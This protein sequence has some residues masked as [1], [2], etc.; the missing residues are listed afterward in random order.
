VTGRTR[1]W[2]GTFVLIPFVFASNVYEGALLPKLL[3]LQLGLL[4][5]NIRLLWP[6]V[7]Q[8]IPSRLL[9]PTAAWSLALALSLLQSVNRTESQAQLSQYLSFALVPLLL[10]ATLG[11]RDL[12]PLFRAMVW[13]SIPVGVIGVI[14]YLGFGFLDL[15]SNAQP[16]A[17]FFHRNAAAGYL[18]AILPLSVYCFF[19]ARGRSR[20]L[21]AAAMCLALAYLVFTRTR[22][23]WIGVLV[24]STGIFLLNRY[25]GKP[26]SGESRNLKTVVSL[27]VV[28]IL[29]AG[30]IPDGLSSAKR[31][32]FDDKKDSALGAVSSIVSEGGDRGRPQLWRHTLE[33]IADRAVFGVG[34]GNW[35]FQYPAYAAGDH[36]NINAAPRRPHN[37]LL[38][39]ASETGLVGLAAYISLVGLTFGIGVRL[40]QDGPAH[41]RRVALACLFILLAH[42]VDGLFNFPRERVGGASLFWLAVGALWVVAP[43]DTRRIRLSAM[44]GLVPLVLI[45]WSAQMTVRRIGYDYHHLQVHIAERSGDWSTVLDQGPRALTYGDFRANTLIAMGRAFYRTGDAVSAITAHE[46]ALTLHPN[47][48]NAHNNLGIA[49]RRV[50]RT[51][52]AVLSLKAAIRLYPDFSQAR[53]NLGNALRDRGEVDASIEVFK[54]LIRRGTWLPQVHINLGR[55]FLEKGDVPNARTSYI[56]ALKLDPQ[57]QAARK[58]LEALSPKRDKPLDRS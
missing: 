47:S 57:N 32:A 6:R 34:L 52:E 51:D 50:G 49:Y 37:D 48:L 30:T 33:M 14:Q 54:D 2:A 55:S 20:R 24:A 56:N 29:I 23:A 46:R 38:W 25:V 12:L 26:R 9:W 43:R 8:N 44:L 17:M 7:R 40:V 28:V 3:V 4:C 10:T 19:E 53:N 1:L 35:E 21:Y 58:A 42:T 22:G 39:I 5:V 45:I 11:A 15:P 31:S 18:T 13:A 41:T 36:L 16:S 27:A